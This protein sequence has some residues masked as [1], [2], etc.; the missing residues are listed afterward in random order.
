MIFWGLQGV[1][2]LLLGVLRT[3]LLLLLLSWSP[4]AQHLHYYNNN[5]WFIKLMMMLMILYMQICNTILILIQNLKASNSFPKL[6]NDYFPF[7]PFLEVIHTEFWIRNSEFWIL[8]SEF[9]IPFF[10]FIQLINCFFILYFNFDDGDDDDAF[11]NLE[12]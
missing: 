9:R 11:H 7:C 4:P 6:H 12:H 8:N 5:N 1:I 3:L 10:F 2:S